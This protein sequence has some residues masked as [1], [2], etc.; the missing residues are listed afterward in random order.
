MNKDKLD[1][2]STM[3]HVAI[4]AIIAAIGSDCQRQDG[5][6]RPQLFAHPQHRDIRT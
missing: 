4:I 3:N 6:K 2:R 1:H 5:G